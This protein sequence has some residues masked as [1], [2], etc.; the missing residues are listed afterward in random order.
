[1]WAGPEA[2]PAEPRTRRLAPRDLHLLFR[3]LCIIQSRLT[4]VRAER[5]RLF[6]ANA[7][8][9]KTDRTAGPQDGMPGPDVGNVRR[10]LG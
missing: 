5:H 7:R 1:M 4:R 3:G 6:T 10:T 2:H 8:G 9:N